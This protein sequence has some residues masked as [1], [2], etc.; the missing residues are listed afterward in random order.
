MAALLEGVAAA[1]GGAAVPSVEAGAVALAES[2]PVDRAVQVVA[3]SA[4]AFLAEAGAVVRAAAFSA[5]VEPPG[6][7][8]VGSSPEG[9]RWFSYLLPYLGGLNSLNPRG[10]RKNEI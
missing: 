7:V 3:F 1:A 10:W 8:E 5:E 4:A 2:R 9:R 6:R